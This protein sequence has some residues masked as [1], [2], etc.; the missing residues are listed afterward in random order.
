[1]YSLQVEG[2]SCHHCISKVTRSVQ[3]VDANAKVSV[4]LGA[5]RVQVDSKADLDEI[6]DAIAEAGYPVK[7]SKIV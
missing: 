4:D 3:G 5:H 6:A 1:M 2:M 7:A